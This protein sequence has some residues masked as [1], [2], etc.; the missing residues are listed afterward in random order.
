MQGKFTTY[1]VIEF[2][3]TARRGSTNLATTLIEEKIFF[4]MTETINIAF[5]QT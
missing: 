4:C 5:Y 1:K 2:K 3:V